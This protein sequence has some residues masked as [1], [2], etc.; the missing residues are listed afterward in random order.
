MGRFCGVS[1]LDDFTRLAYQNL[2]SQMC[3]VRRMGSE[4]AD[5]RSTRMSLVMYIS[6]IVMSSRKVESQPQSESAIVC[7]LDI[8]L[9]LIIASST[10]YS[11]R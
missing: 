9:K 5:G 1:G 7:K 6:S 10:S 3:R 2:R 4:S 11:V 8:R